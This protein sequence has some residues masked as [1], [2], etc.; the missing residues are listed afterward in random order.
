M[1][2]DV[3]HLGCAHTHVSPALGDDHERGD[4]VRLACPKC[5]G[6]GEHEIRAPLRGL[7]A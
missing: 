3:R 4:T 7:V 2:Y 1:K 5:G 6:Y